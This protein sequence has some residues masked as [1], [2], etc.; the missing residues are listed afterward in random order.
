MIKVVLVDDHKV[1]LQGMQSLLSTDP[2]IEVDKIFTG[3][4]DL[5]QYLNDQKSSPML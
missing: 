5:F 1:F 2:D 3:G 4:K